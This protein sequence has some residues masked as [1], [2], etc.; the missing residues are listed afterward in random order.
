MS[1]F[2]IHT[3]APVNQPFYALDRDLDPL[4]ID[5]S[6]VYKLS[7]KKS[8]EDAAPVLTFITGGANGQGTIEVLNGDIDEDGVARDYFLFTL[9]DVALVAALTPGAYFADLLR[10]DD[11]NWEYGMQVDVETGITVP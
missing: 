11:P 5:H 3:N 6:G 2:I 7:L 8:R 1:R 4:P 9:T 10:T